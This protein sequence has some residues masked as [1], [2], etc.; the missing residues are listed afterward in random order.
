MEIET[1]LKGVSAKNLVQKNCKTIQL[2]EMAVSAVQMMQEN[3]ISQ[4]IV[5]DGNK[6][7]GMVHVHDLLKEGIL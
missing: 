7:L 5:M 1:E 3:S 2:G 4:L 6:Y